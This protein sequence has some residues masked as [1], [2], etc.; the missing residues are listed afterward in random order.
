MEWEYPNQRLAEY[1]QKEGI[2]FLDLLPEFRRYARLGWKPSLDA[3]D[4]YWPYNGHLNIK[5]NRLAGLLIGRD[6]LERPF[7]E[8]HDQSTRLANIQQLLSAETDG[9]SME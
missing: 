9:T 1:F 2:A 6:M 4:L 3:R 8:V 5:G 7:L